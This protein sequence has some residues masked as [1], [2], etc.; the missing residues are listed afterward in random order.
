MSKIKKRSEQQQVDVFDTNSA[1]V[2]KEKIVTELTEEER[3]ELQREAE[4]ALKSIMWAND[5]LDW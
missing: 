1:E 3:Q 4:E 5:P 2:K